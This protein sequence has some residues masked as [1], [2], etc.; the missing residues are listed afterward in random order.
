MENN[1][2]ELTIKFEGGDSGSSSSTKAKDDNEKVMNAVANVAKAQIIKPFISTAEQIYFNNLQTNTGSSQLVERQRLL[3]DG[4][5]QG[6][7]LFQ[8]A[9]GGIAFAGA[10]GL[11]VGAGAG[12]GIALYGINF[13]SNLLVRQNQLNNQK[14]IEDVNIEYQ[15]T[16]MGFAN[17]K[18]RTGA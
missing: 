8:S 16:R 12:I 1:R 13:M 2:Y 6:I 10:L 9:Q 4:V 14:K 11:S 3:L 7:N 5:R 18:S 15:K 17:N